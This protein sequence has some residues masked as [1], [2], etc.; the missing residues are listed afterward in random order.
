MPKNDSG[1]NVVDFTERLVHKKMDEYLDFQEEEYD[2]QIETMNTIY[3]AI[4]EACAETGVADDSDE[5]VKDFAYVMEAVQSMVNRQFGE[6][7]TFQKTIDKQLEV[8]RDE[9][10]WPIAVDWIPKLTPKE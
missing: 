7:H 9:E 5:F 8:T 2:E 10:G 6:Y 3:D 4:M 1:N